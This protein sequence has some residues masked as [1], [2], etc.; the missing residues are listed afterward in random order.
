MSP[1]HVLEPTY[2]RLKRELMGGR[3]PQDTRL[4][5]LRIAEDYGVSATPVRDSLN[6]L[7][8]EGLVAMRPGEG[9]RVPRLT[10]KSVRDMLE[11]HKLLVTTA[12]SSDFSRVAGLR[13]PEQVSG[14]AE[15]VT[16]IFV[17]IAEASGNSAIV[18]AVRAI[19]ERL[20]PIRMLE[21]DVLEGANE[22]LEQL[23]EAA[24]QRPAVLGIMAAAYHDRR[25]E[26]SA[27]LIAA[28]P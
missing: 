14:Y 28:L 24:D 27:A 13:D 7:T 9:Y 26:R 17:G 16:A 2:Q 11:L 5:A 22:E 20:F 23:R 3:W 1:S 10:E 18:F 15:A 8:G 19:G 12:L 6:R 21:P 25:I 4:E